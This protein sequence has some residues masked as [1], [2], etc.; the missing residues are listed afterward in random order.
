[1]CY[2][3]AQ[4]DPQDPVTGYDLNLGSSTGSALGDDFWVGI[5]AGHES[6]D[7]AESTATSYSMQVGQSFY[8]TIASSTDEDWIRIN[9]VAG[10]NY[11]IRLLGQGA[12]FLTDPFVRIRNSSGTELSFNDD[13]FTSGSSTH[14]R[15]SALVFTATTTGTYYIEADAYST[16]TGDY[17]LSVTEHDVNGPVFTADEIAWQLTNNG[18][19]FFSSPE[20]AAFNVGA[21]GS[22]T[23]NITALTAE[24]QFLARHA[25]Q[26]W[27]NVTGI[28]FV[29]TAGAAEITFDDAAASA[30][31]N[32]STSGSTIV[33]STVNIGLDWLTNFGTT[34]LSYSF[35]TY[36]H[37]IGHALGLGHGGNYN[38]SA[39]YG[40]DNYYLN[41]SLA[42]SI[43]SYMQAENDE[44]AGGG[45]WNTYTDA[46]F[47]Y[48][49]TPQIADIIAIQNLYGG[50][51][52]A[53]TGNTTWGFG[54][55]TGIV[56]LDTAVNA[57]ALMAMTVYDSGG[58]DT[59]NFANTGAQQV[60]S[61]LAESMS[62]VLGGRHNVAIARGVVIENANG[63]SAA[64]HI[65]GNSSNNLIDGGGGGDRM[66][67][68]GGNDTYII[69][70][71]A[72]QVIEFSGGGTDMVKSWISWTLANNIERLQLL[73]IGNNAN[74][75]GLANQIYGNAGNNLI[76]GGGAA[77]R[78]EGFAG[79]D[80]YIVDNTSDRTIEAA[81]GGTDTVKSWITWALSGNIERL[82]LLGIGNNATGN[83]LNN[84]IYGNAGTNV[85]NGAGGGDRMQGFA[86][87]DTYIIDNAGDQVVESAGGG[88]DTVKSWISWT[89]ANNIER[90]QLLGIGNNATGNGLN[91]QIY[92]NA[93]TNVINGAGGADR[94]QG[95]AGNDTYIVDNAGDQ[96]IEAAGGG[97][98]TV[99]SWISHTLGAN[100]E[101]L[102][103]LG[104]GNN[105]AGNSLN[106][107]IFGNAGNNRINGLAGNDTMTG[108]AGFDT[109][110]FNTALNAATNRDTITDFSVA[111]D[112]I[113]LENAIFTA[114]GPVGTL[115]AAAFHI[116]AAATT[117]AHRIV[118]NSA[119]G[120][121]T[122]D[123]N[124]S[125]AGGATQFAILD[126]GLALTRADF[127][128]S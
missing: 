33:S 8:G 39:T 26:A 73:G 51:N 119:T 104:V 85:I 76:D 31:A 32:T 20:A 44:F 122:Y 27:E 102:Q 124:G 89:L 126:T 23:V 72:D 66:E 46:S 100:I 60:I 48:L 64:D 107:Q 127:L 79:N 75:N 24:G 56:A 53:F 84:Q 101:R 114:I 18:E 37:E 2:L 1:M 3:C 36:I 117:A 10:Q 70:S 35:E 80:T 108:G 109:F 105:G 45:D 19:A 99:K 55:N 77:D 62:S 123:S 21:D 113:Q 38:G 116:G 42:W 41:D 83:G 59:L 88:T 65:L 25:L 63:G 81:G 95:F 22:L 91:N 6:A 4:L 112:T 125:G 57:G 111:N 121:L 54:S 50:F 74:G 96:I 92:G 103:L 71:L 97:T 30:F 11:D 86:G 47:R 9:L 17:L 69:D 67:G 120:T 13:G 14:E 68:R 94:M 5:A 90:L 118:Y 34:L 15:D 40:T 78:M 58:I 61:L 93:G 106:N 16:E 52:G 7:A 110:I 128:I 29:E 115:A 28:N 43:M 98:D 82:Q 87:N 12:N 49:M